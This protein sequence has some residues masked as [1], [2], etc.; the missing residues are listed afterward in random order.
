M[1]LKLEKQRDFDRFK[2]RKNSLFAKL[3]DY[4]AYLE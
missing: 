2:T 3:E 4:G 1:C